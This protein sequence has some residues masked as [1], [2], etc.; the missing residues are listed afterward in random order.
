MCAASLYGMPTC[1]SSLYDM[2]TCGIS[3]YG[4]PTCGSSLYGMD[5]CGI[6]LRAG[7]HAPS[8]DMSVFSLCGMIS[9]YSSLCMRGALYLV[10]LGKS[11]LEILEFIAVGQQLCTL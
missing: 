4:M 10:T 6:S 2:D 5:T 3:L 9:Y 1:G 8:R 7:I 11:L